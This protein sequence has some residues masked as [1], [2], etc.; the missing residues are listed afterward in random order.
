VWISFQAC[1]QLSLMYSLPRTF[2]NQWR[3]I[4][5]YWW[6]K[7]SPFSQ[8]QKLSNKWVREYL[9]PSQIL[10]VR[11]SLT[12]AMIK[13]RLNLVFIVYGSFIIFELE[14]DSSYVLSFPYTVSCLINI[15]MIQTFFQISR[16]WNV[17]VLYILNISASHNV[18]H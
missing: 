17:E 8:S 15:W 18:Y 5:W 10:K 9:F 7:L 14:L 13:C 16:E 12:F 1:L 6:T 4:Q 2:E 3:Q 11:W